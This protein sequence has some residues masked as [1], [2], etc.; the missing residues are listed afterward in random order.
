MYN[1]V[2]TTTTNSPTLSRPR[3]R[4]VVRVGYNNI[5]HNTASAG[6]ARIDG[7]VA[8]KKLERNEERAKGRETERERERQERQA[9]PVL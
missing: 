1:I 6:Q 4:V 8:P 9:Q 3:D 2:V 5:I 7:I